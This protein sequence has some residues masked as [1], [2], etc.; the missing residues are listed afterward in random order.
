M[1]TYDDVKIV[2]PNRISF[3]LIG[4]VLVLVPWYIV[5]YLSKY[6]LVLLR[7]YDNTVHGRILDTF[8][9]TFF[10]TG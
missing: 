9:S 6:T 10:C 3:N 1:T 8:S 2:K 5:Q 7:S 4:P